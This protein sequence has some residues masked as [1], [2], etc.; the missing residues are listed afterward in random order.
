VTVSEILSNEELRRREFPV[1]QNKIFLA[2]AGDCPLP[3]RVAQAVT[4]CA[5]AAALEVWLVNLKD[6]TVKVDRGPNFKG[7][8]NKTDLRAGDKAKLSP[9]SRQA[10]RKS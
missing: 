10:W 9:M 7:H 2:H 1:A 4:D 3:H 8:D 6:L 5:R